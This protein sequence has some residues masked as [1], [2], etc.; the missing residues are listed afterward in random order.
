[1]TQHNK[2]LFQEA[3]ERLCMTHGHELSGGN[4]SERGCVGLRETRREKNGT[5][6]IE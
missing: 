6:V 2:D 5:T 4:A 1:M 3:K